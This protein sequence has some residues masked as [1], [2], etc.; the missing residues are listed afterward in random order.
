[1]ASVTTPG[2]TT[3]QPLQ[4]RRSITPN[5]IPAASTV[6]E[7]ELA[8]NLKDLILYTKDDQGN[9]V[10]LG[11]NYDAILAAHFQSN[12]PHGTSK[13][14]VG[15]GNVPNENLKPLYY[16]NSGSRTLNT[17]RIMTRMDYVNA[18]NV[19]YTIDASKYAVGDQFEIARLADS[20]GEITIALNSGDWLIDGQRD[21][22]DLRIHEQTFMAIL[23][24]AQ[25][26]LWTVKVQYV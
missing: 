15:L 8:A 4:L 12:N 9:I 13:A 24:K 19:T 16:Y 1:M 25:S 3:L 22:T 2:G 26:D 10:K 7:G 6:E 11:Q 17:P 20:A 23:T 18:A 14:D 21:S 5:A